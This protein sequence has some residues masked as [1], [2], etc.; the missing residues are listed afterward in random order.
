MTEME[1]LEV[2]RVV[3]MADGG[4]SSCISTL[5]EELQ[6]AFPQFSWKTLLAGFWNGKKN[7]D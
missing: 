1:A 2:A 3:S 6:V 4:C 7:D 5:E